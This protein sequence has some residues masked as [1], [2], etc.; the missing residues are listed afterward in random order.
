MK[1]LV[2]LCSV[3]SLAACF[4]WSCT[5]KD[6]QDTAENAAG[7]KLEMTA[8][9]NS[10]VAALKSGP[11]AVFPEGSKLRL[12]ITKGSLGD[13]YESEASRGVASTLTGGKW[14]QSPAVNLYGHNATVFAFYPYTAI[15]SDGTALPIHSGLT[16][17]MY[18][19]HTQG[20]IPVNRDNPQVRLMMNHALALVQFNLYRQDYP[21]KGDLTC[22]RITNA[23][24][25]AVVYNSAK[26]N[27]AT[28]EVKDHSGQDMAIQLNSTSLGIIP[29]SQ[30]TDEGTFHKLL[31]IPTGTTKADG[32][33]LV[34]FTIDGRDY[35]WEAPAGTQWKQGTKNT[36][37]V[38]LKG[39]EL[40]IAG[41]GITD[42]TDGPVGNVV[43][44]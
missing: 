13:D 4:L 42:W 22:I 23:P 2:I 41:F 8:G 7:T 17:Y 19:T 34:T 35:I 43:L 26:L 21:W 40:Q 24:G 38:L 32:E 5:D 12:F 10:P 39:H 25:K 14:E 30:S 15:A 36:Y 3:L 28:G 18:G 31:L 1:K 9:I 29:G 33:I 37:Q 27:I 20:H 11:V 44:Q 16:D 6:E